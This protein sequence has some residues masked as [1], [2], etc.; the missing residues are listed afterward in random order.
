MVAC[1]ETQV[2]GD[3]FREAGREGH[4]EDPLHQVV[5]H[6]DQ[7]VEEK[8]DVQ[9]LEVHRNQAAQTRVRWV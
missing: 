4:L 6:Q 5:G 1:L 8:A 9:I 2:E 3:P 7:K